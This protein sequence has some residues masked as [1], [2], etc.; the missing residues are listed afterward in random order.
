MFY[1]W[2]CLPAD[3]ARDAS[4]PIYTVPT[5]PL[6]HSVYMSVYITHYYPTKSTP[7]WTTQSES[8]HTVEFLREELFECVT[9]GSHQWYQWSTNCRLTTPDCNTTQI[10]IVNGQVKENIFSETAHEN[11]LRLSN[12]HTKHFQNSDWF[13]ILFY[14]I[15]HL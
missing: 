9:S 5:V 1:R 10:N 4:Q 14:K 13:L 8:A 6:V 2:S 11:A 12:A 3:R 15:C 7:A